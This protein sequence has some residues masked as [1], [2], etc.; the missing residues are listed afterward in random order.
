M[1]RIKIISMAAVILLVLIVACSKKIPEE[2]EYDP[3]QYL[4][5]KIESV[6]L[7]RTG[8]IR[9]FAG[10]RLW[11][12]I[13]GG[14]ELYLQF[15]FI[16]VATA[17]YKNPD[18]EMVADIYHFENSTNAYGLYTQLRPTEPNYIL[19]GVEGFA[20]PASIIFV[21]GPFLVRLMTYKDDAPGNLAL[22]A[23]AQEI[24][25]ILPGA[26][27][28]PNTFLL[29]PVNNVI[30]TSDKY[31][32]ESFH[33]LKF[34]SRVYSQDYFLDNDTVTL[35]LTPDEFGEKYLRWTEYAAAMKKLGTP[36]DSLGFD[37][38]MVFLMEDNISGSVLAG[39]KKGRLM[40]M[41]KY[42]ELHKKFL[43]DWINSFQ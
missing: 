10:N 42:N 34:M 18:V 21:K 19:L 32:S 31:Y 5:E 28:R 7:A 22:T 17:D 6:N 43:S 11:E 9:S 33:G 13:D 36:P 8:E 15:R 4:P 27:S 39:L 20:A 35:F 24:S 23:L 2:S 37:S 12:Y 38:T 40:G 29:F 14:A 16:D 41:A 3:K 1:L 30:G 25:K 26:T